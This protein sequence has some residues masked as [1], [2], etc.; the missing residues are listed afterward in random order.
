VIKAIGGNG[1]KLPENRTGEYFLPKN[2]A[3]NSNSGLRIEDYEL[4]IKAATIHLS[5]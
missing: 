1:N 3:E 5:K 2:K 4:R